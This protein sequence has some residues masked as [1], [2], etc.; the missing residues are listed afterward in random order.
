MVKIYVVYHNTF[1]DTNVFFTD[2][3]KAQ[4]M[5]NDLANNTDTKRTEWKIRVL[6]EGELF[7]ADMTAF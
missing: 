1:E 3:N 6:R 4:E 2:Y 5:L 7:E